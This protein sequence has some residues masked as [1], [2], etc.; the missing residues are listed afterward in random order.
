MRESN[1][2]FGKLANESMDKMLKVLL[3]TLTVNYKLWDTFDGTTKNTPRKQE[4]GGW[5]KT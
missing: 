3:Q 4:K 2:Q 5:E 1:D